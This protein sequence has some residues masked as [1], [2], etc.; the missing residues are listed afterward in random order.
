MSESITLPEVRTHLTMKSENGKTGA[1]PV[2][3]SGAQ[4]CPVSCPLASR[5]CYAK[6]GPM[7]LHWNHVTAGTRGETWSDFLATIAALPAGTLWRHNQAG[8]LPGRGDTLDIPALAA[9]AAANSGKHGFTYT[10]KPL[11]SRAEKTAVKKAVAQGFAINLSADNLAEADAL[12][13]LGIAPVV[14]TVPTFADMPKATPDGR[15]LVPCP[16]QTS[17]VPCAQCMLCAKPWRKTIVAF[18]AHGTGKTA[19]TW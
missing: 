10:H 17:A 7:R 3:T 5:G 12:A 16:Q 4:T 14:V 2:S 6:H 19:I 9:L 13:A 11:R 1:M 18:A 8:D 15:P